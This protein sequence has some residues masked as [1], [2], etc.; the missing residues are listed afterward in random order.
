MNLFLAYAKYQK[1]KKAKFFQ[2]STDEVYGSVSKDYQKKLTDM[3]HP[4]LIRHLKVV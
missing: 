4:L 3:S 1:I 2:I